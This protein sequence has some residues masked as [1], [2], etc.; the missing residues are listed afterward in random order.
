MNIYQVL[1]DSFAWEQQGTCARNLERV[2]D[3]ATYG[4]NV[5]WI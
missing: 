1:E 5:A 4:I 3:A 2:V